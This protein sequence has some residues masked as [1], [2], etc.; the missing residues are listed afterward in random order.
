MAILIFQSLSEAEKRKFFEIEKTVEWIKSNHY[1][2][3]AAQFPDSLL[4]F[5]SDVVH[6]LEEGIDIKAFILGDSSYRRFV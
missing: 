6:W 1:T 3:V 2:R 5:A 4:R